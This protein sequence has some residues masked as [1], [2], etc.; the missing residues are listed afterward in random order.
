MRL[1]PTLLLDAYCRGYFPMAEEDGAVYWYDPDPRAV[2][3]LD[4]LH[5]PRS[6][7]QRMRRPDYEVR[8]DTAFREV[9]RACAAPAPGREKTW[10]SGEFIDLYSR[11][12]DLGLAHSVET[13]MEGRLVGGLYGVAIQGLFAGESMFSRRTDASKI[14]L[15]RLVERL[16]DRGYSLLDVQ[17][18]TDHL[19]RFGVVEIPRTRYR[20]LL[21]EALTREARF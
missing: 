12:H 7:R 8:C 10:I 6:L 16:R 13:W 20:T 18:T 5:V 15:V 19:R 2:L 11:L 14:A 1:T 3:P 17:F 9:L 4:G 21:A